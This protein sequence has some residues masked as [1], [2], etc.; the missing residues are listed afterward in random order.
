[1]SAEQDTAMYDQPDDDKL[2]AD[3]EREAEFW[4]THPRDDARPDKADM[5]VQIAARAAAATVGPWE[6]DQV[7]E[8]GECGVFGK[9]NVWYPEGRSTVALWM[10]YDDA[11]FVAHAREDIPWLLNALA[12]Q[13]ATIAAVMK[14][15]H[16]WFNEPVVGI[17]RAA[18]LRRLDAILDKPPASII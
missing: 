5:L 16:D 7:P 3:A 11:E 4:R 12:E 14:W 13:A 8:T 10:H 2:N 1:M 9:P 17:Y 6:T 15:R 18:H